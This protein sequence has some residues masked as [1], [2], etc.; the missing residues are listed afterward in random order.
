MVSDL[1]SGRRTSGSFVL[2]HQKRK[3]YKDNVA[4]LDG[5]QHLFVIPN[6]DVTWEIKY[7]CGC[8][9]GCKPLL[10]TPVRA[11]SLSSGGFFP[12]HS[13]K[14]PGQFHMEREVLLTLILC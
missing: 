7:N 5:V 8:T 4:R 10:C 14:K 11:V 2:V 12:N 9:F 3:Q 1:V 6:S 13:T